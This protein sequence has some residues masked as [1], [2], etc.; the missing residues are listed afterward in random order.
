MKAIFV[1]TWGWINIFNRKES[2]HNSVINIYHEVRKEQGHI[3]TTDYV[4]DELYTLF[5]KRLSL[6]I[7]HKA[8]QTISETIEK[9]Y[10]KLLWIKPERFDAAS[11]LRIK[12]YDKPD[13][14][15]TDLTSMSVMKEVGI[16]EI[17]TG[18]AHFTHV[19]M[20]FTLLP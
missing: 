8:F 1:D 17:L 7:A 9:G 11:R 4:L 2:Y 3:I 5:F 13:I 19:G 12:F 14:S 15:F 16:S 20:G 10:V 6:E 18:D